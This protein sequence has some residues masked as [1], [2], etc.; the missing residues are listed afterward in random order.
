MT[1]RKKRNI[2]THAQNGNIKSN[3]K[4]Q[5]ELLLQGLQ[6]L[7]VPASNIKDHSKKGYV[8]QKQTDQGRKPRHKKNKGGTP[9]GK[10]GKP[11]SS[12]Q[13]EHQD[14]LFEGKVLKPIN[15]K[16]SPSVETKKSFRSDATT[17]MGK[18]TSE[19][20]ANDWNVA[21]TFPQPLGYAMKNEG[22][23]CFIAAALHLLR[24][25]GIAFAAVTE[26]QK[27]V[28]GMLRD[29]VRFDNSNWS[30][31]GANTIQISE[32]HGIQRDSAEYLHELIIK[33]G[34]EKNFM[35]VQQSGLLKTSGGKGWSI[36]RHPDTSYVRL[37]L[38]IDCWN[39]QALNATISQTEL[40]DFKIDIPTAG[41]GPPLLFV[42]LQRF[43]NKQMKLRHRAVTPESI[44]YGH[45]TYDRIRTIHHGGKGL[46]SGHFW[47]S[48]KCQTT[49][50]EHVYNDET[51]YKQSNMV[52]ST[53]VYVLLY[54]KRKVN[55]QGQSSQQIYKEKL[56]ESILSTQ[57]MSPK[58]EEDD[59]MQTRK[60]RIVEETSEAIVTAPVNLT[61]ISAQDKSVVEAK[62]PPFTAT[63]TYTNVLSID[64][65]I[66][67]TSIFGI[68][69]NTG[70]DI[71][72]KTRLELVTNDDSRA[73]APTPVRRSS[74]NLTAAMAQLKN[75]PID[76]DL[77]TEED[78][79]Y[80]PKRRIRDAK[81][82]FAKKEKKQ[83]ME[84]DEEAGYPLDQPTTVAYFCS[85]CQAPIHAKEMGPKHHGHYTTN[86]FNHIIRKRKH[87]GR[88]FIVLEV[89]DYL[90]V[91]RGDS[92]DPHSTIIGTS[93]TDPLVVEK[94]IKLAMDLS[95]RLKVEKSY[96]ALGMNNLL[97]G[98]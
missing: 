25:A 95:D 73:I 92:L 53:S 43:D 54:K 41:L 6:S 91:C 51:I 23:T 11:R 2:A 76:P 96:L 7:L 27:T 14:P 68:P 79:I 22:N 65:M 42:T 58:P 35:G 40:N 61:I 66:P 52:T 60:R 86:V 67:A 49:S 8:P 55:R 29:I 63:L 64:K 46:D 85:L 28:Q 33:L 37:P 20:W 81:V 44:E 84:A 98:E 88:R 50:Y 39:S 36:D 13:K 26:F 90:Q 83:M 57:E 5:I 15:L 94:V 12:S 78:M 59:T 45:E 82:T 74:Q 16:R 19:I 21:H 70:S 62:N 31:R 24:V 1:T 56:V 4:G 71:I 34:I 69:L 77:L 48:E 89:K 17:R 10:G 38:T 3:G 93:V 87:L 18:S 47:M 72:P 97:M 80:F 30:V 9:A 75:A 32:P